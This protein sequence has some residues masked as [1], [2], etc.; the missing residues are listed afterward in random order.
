MV[1]SPR[2]K[3][4]LTANF[5]ALLLFCGGFTTGDIAWARSNH[6][7]A[8][9]QLG[10][11]SVRMNPDGTGLTLSA[12][13]P[14]TG[15]ETRNLSIL[16]LPSPYRIVVDIPNT[17]LATAQKVLPV[18][19]NG[20]E[21]IELTD[22]SSP[23]YTATRA[24]IYVSDHQTLIRL[25]PVFEGNA[26]RLEGLAPM[27]LSPAQM[28]STSFVTPSA[29]IP[30]AKQPAVHK[31]GSRSLKTIQPLP[32][33][34][35]PS[36]A[37]AEVKPPLPPANV[38][39]VT[40]APLP[41]KQATLPQA[42]ETVLGKPAPSGVSVV[43][44]VAFRDSKLILKAANGADLRI[45][46]RFVLTAPSRLVLD[47][48]NAVLASRSL[49]NPISGNT[50]EIQQIRVGQFDESTVRIVIQSTE[51]EQFE[52]IYPG[53]ERNV[54]AI[55]PYSS[56]S[57]TKLSANTRLGEVQSIDL[58]R[59]S[60]GTVLRLTASAPIVHRFV[61]R[62]DR[63]VLDLLNQ[64][65]HP[66]PIGFDQKQYPEIEKMRLEPL[67]D[68]QPNSKLS[69]NLAAANVR[70]VPTLSDDGKVLELLIAKADTANPAAGLANLI[71]LGA[72]GNAPFPARIVVDAGHGGKDIGATR[73]G[74]REKDL[75]LSLA[76]MLRDALT[77]K[78]FKVYMTRST[79]EFLP[80]PRITAITNEIRPDLFIS[81]HH[82]A[83][84]NPALAGIETYYFTPQ[85]VP[86]A[87]RVH[88][89]EIN[90][91]GVRDGGVKQARFYVIH[92]TSVP[93]I[94]CEVGYVSNPSELTDLQTMDRKL[95][96]A[97]SIADGVVDYLKTRV[98]AK[99][100]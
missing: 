66:T 91:V 55:S 92:H 97:R 26:L 53:S 29:P 37:M 59:E 74:V 98:S 23:F 75:N 28:A 94:L 81:I 11:V 78:G 33:L 60:G 30:T 93:A 43:E 99:A 95:K 83:S 36:P 100:R 20:I 1:C 46:N 85:S 17:H 61:K 89:R 6:S 96:T 38:P 47:V 58:K 48:E 18:N 31:R 49:M 22:N 5:A 68:G 35:K 80:L 25:N 4:M 64:A 79:D 24:V 73:S 72:A 62:D 14:F 88:A 41:Q 12:N 2:I 10:L 16:R 82:N 86:L 57:I 90:A 40:A 54:L 13:R 71:G 3:R 27:A 19:H 67:T 51:P 69:I 52:S 65:A 63:V 87:K 15:N 42:T 56:T 34:A 9:G 45:K 84:V 76:L 21:R 32:P 77:A 7:A 70:V 39:A 44:E 50:P 8:S